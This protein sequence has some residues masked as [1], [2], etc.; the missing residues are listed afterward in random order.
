MGIYQSKTAM[1]QQPGENLED[2]QKRDKGSQI[3]GRGRDEEKKT[4][5]GANRSVIMQLY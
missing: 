4:Q 3:E 1:C 5:E 2:E